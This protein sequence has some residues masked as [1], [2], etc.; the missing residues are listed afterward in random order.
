MAGQPENNKLLYKEEHM[1]CNNYGR[2]EKSVI[3]FFNLDIGQSI[4]YSIKEHMML[5]VKRGKL[6]LEWPEYELQKQADEN[7]FVLL[8]SETVV[9]MKVREKSKIMTCRF[10]D[11]I[12]LCEMLRLGPNDELYGNDTD[13]IND[14][15][16]YANNVI[17]KQIDSIEYC[18]DIGV[19][20]KNYQNMKIME[21]LYMFRFFYAKE[22]LT[23]FFGPM[24]NRDTAFKGFVLSNWHLVSSIEELAGKANCHRDTFTRKFHK[25][26]GTTPRQWMKERKAELIMRELKLSSKP[27]KQIAEEL[28]FS[29]PAALNRFCKEQFNDTPAKIRSQ[30]SGIKNGGNNLKKKYFFAGK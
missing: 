27:L 12:K 4:E 26:M 16:L 15:I 24:L 9:K 10:S 14:E 18:M 1:C 13:I 2:E 6:D 29:S 19:R 7:G 23:A 8:P 28:D 11:D 3:R 20:C 5:F 17:K 22:K 30:Q 25:V 21:I